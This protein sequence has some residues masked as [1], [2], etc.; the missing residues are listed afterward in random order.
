MVG[1]GNQMRSLEMESDSDTFFL[2]LDTVMLSSE[3]TWTNVGSALNM[4]FISG[5]TSC[6]NNE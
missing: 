2:T 1:L 5:V 3:F 4:H 6:V